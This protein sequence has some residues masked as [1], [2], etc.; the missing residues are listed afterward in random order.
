MAATSVDQLGLVAQN[1]QD[2][3][4]AIIGTTTAGVPASTF[5]SAARPAWD[6][7]FLSVQVSLLGD[8]FTSP[9]EVL[10]T[11]LRNH[12]GEL[13]VSTFDVWIVRCGPNLA[14]KLPPSDETKTTNSLQVI[15][16][17]WALWNGLRAVQDEIF[18]GCLGVYFDNWAPQP[19]Q[20]GYVGG[21]LTIRASVEGYVP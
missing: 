7:E 4:E 1:L 8:D 20:G 13:I 18:D 16:D 2:A 9:L 5:I 15:Q 3:A 10:E 6:C 17:G 11:K 19:E 12:Y 14:K 21:V